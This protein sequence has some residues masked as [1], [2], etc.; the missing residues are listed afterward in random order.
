[1]RARKTVIVTGV[2]ALFTSAVPVAVLH[3]EEPLQQPAA[4]QAAG[5]Q[6]GAAGQQPG[7]AG[8]QPGAAGQQ[9]GAAQKNYKDRAEY[10]LYAKI[11]QTAD[12]AAR[13]ELL[14]TW[15]DKYPQTDFAQERAQYFV[16]TLNQLAPKDP[17]ARKKLLDKTA[18]LLKTDPKN[19]Q[20]L[21]F[22]TLWGPAVGGTSPTPEVL[23]QVD[24]AAHGV[25][26]NANDAF[27]ASKK[28]ANVSA[29]DFEKAK[30]QALSAAHNALAWQAISK[31][32]NAATESEYKASLQANPAQPN[33]SAAYGKL[34]VEQKKYPEGLFEYAR[35][36]QYDG[37]GALPPATRQQ[38]LDYFNKAYKDFHGS[39]EGKQQM[40]DQAKTS[41]LPPEGLQVT[42][43]ADLANKQADAMNARIASD[44]GFK[45]WY[46]VKTS[47]QEKGDAFF[48]S[49]I[50]GAELPGETVPN[51]SFTGTVISVDPPDAPTKVVVG[52]EDPTKPDASLEF[53]QP[54]PAAALEK[55][56]VG[57]KLDFSGIADS[58]TKDPY[59]VTFKDPTVPGVQT[60]APA[61]KGTQRHRR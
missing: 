56:K 8:Q 40:M 15:Q 36:G 38:L 20:A 52:I 21:Y 6:P 28:P 27:D 11:T 24:S 58:Y 39:D 57:E 17:A 60:A 25:I 48:N 7:A 26:D 45:I 3:A 61:K 18:E 53:S 32:D 4:G 22:T 29:E 14:N 50:K 43:A 10:D 42:S 54:L 1:M 37:P 55:V 59:M 23:T 46:A 33:I 9:A 51:K 30:N 12:P 47:L 31:K 16:A 19:F 44:P 41:A 49:D 5:Q 35:A 34:L 2:F 13:L